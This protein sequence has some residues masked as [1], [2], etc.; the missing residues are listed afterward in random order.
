MI[1]EP[2]LDFLKKIG[3]EAGKA[4]E[5]KTVVPTSRPGIR[6][7]RLR[8]NDIPMVVAW[9]AA[10][11]GITGEDMVQEFVEVCTAKDIPLIV[12]PEAAKLDISGEDMVLECG[13]R[14]MV[15]LLPLG[16][17]KCSLSLAAPEDVTVPKTIVA[18]LP[19]L[20]ERLCR[21][22]G[23]E[24]EIMPWYGVL[25]SA[26]QL[27]IGDTGERFADAIFDQ[28][29][30]GKSLTANGFRVLSTLMDSQAYLIAN[31]VSLREKKDIIDEIVL[32]AQGV[33]AARQTVFVKVN[34]KSPAICDALKGILPAM[35][36]PDVVPLGNAGEFSVSAAAP[37]EGLGKLILQLKKAG[38][39]GILVFGPAGLELVV[40]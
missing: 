20:A 10:D 27:E 7:A 26:P 34:A 32:Y 21:R 17:G 36:S 2:A 39:A 8:S 15:M 24:A 25:E 28:V 37:R 11:L 22:D 40:P 4:D 18:A 12:V 3:I 23:R 19:R 1:E 14:M 29:G 13:A 38:G 9:G 6:M 31:G 35:E 33:L 5:R 30:S 16:F